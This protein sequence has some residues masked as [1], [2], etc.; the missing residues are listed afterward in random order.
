MT[1]DMVEDLVAPF[2]AS[3]FYIVAA[4]ALLVVL[5]M[6]LGWRI[7]SIGAKKRAPVRV[8]TWQKKIDDLR[9]EHRNV[10]DSRVYALALAKLL[11]DFGTEKTGSDMSWMSVRE[12]TAMSGF[13]EF[14]ELLSVLEE[15]S[16]GASPAAPSTAGNGV[17][18][19]SAEGSETAGESGS[20][21]G[22]DLAANGGAVDQPGAAG[23]P[24]TAD[25]TTI[26]QVTE[27][28]KAVIGAW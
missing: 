11:R 17:T 12:A 9:E 24:G 5:A 14:G 26:D 22:A 28:A 15:P 20:T 19:G 8:R 16:F 18:G 2:E 3:P 10:G 13:T 23:G 25:T 21:S 6:W 27:R 7:T 1:D 4:L